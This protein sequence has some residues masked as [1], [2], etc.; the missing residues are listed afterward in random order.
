MGHV[1]VKILTLLHLC[2]VQI[3]SE[4]RLTQLHLPDLG[5]GRA[6]RDGSWGC[7]WRVRSHAGYSGRLHQLLISSI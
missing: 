2:K 4:N 6:A 3:T 1:S 7:S 5:L